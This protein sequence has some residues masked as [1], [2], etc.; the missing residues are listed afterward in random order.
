MCA[1]AVPGNAQQQMNDIEARDPS[2][3]I[4]TRYQKK[5]INQFSL[6]L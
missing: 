4:E 2:A 1:W 3:Q 6:N 5:H